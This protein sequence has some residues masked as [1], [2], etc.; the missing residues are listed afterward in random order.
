[1]YEENL[2]IRRN[3]K[4]KVLCHVFDA[5]RSSEGSRT[6]HHASGHRS[7]VRQEERPTVSPPG[8][9]QVSL[10][11]GVLPRGVCFSS[12]RAVSVTVAARPA[13]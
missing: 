10:G 4:E 1:M 11:S 5:M 7:A 3:D 13:G 2:P 12:A 9:G 6:E 8:L